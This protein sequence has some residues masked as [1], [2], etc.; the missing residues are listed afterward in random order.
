MEKEFSLDFSIPEKTNLF[1]NYP[2]PF[3]TYTNISYQTSETGFVSLKIYDPD[4][5]LVKTLVNDFKKS[6]YYNIDWYGDNDL[7]EK[8]TGG[9]YIL[10]MSL[11][12]Y[13]KSITIIVDK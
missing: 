9:K 5:F 4:G 1:S 13:T 8:I 6:N 7:G 10:R 2:N 12:N 3:S 11:N